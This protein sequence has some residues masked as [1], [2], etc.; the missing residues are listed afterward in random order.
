M[1]IKWR[2]VV[3]KTYNGTDSILEIAF[4]RFN[5]NTMV[6]FFVESQSE[7]ALACDRSMDDVEVILIR[8]VRDK[9]NPYKEDAIKYRTMSFMDRVKFLF[10]NGSDK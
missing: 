2:I 9:F 7:V 6:S 10:A 5:G 8:S 3:I 1:S 4:N